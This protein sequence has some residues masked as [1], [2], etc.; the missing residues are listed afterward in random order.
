M[1]DAI[2]LLERDID[3]HMQAARPWDYAKMLVARAQRASPSDA[4][5]SPPKERVV[6]VAAAPDDGAVEAMLGNLLIESYLAATKS[7]ELVL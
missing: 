3:A 6:K 2:D 7:F 5:L 4:A 1:T